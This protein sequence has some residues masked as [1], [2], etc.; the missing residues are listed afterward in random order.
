MKITEEQKDHITKSI[1]LIKEIKK[2]FNS[3]QNEL[4]E[5][6][7]GE[8]IYENQPFNQLDNITNNL[9]RIYGEYCF[10]DNFDILKHRA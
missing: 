4:N 1:L 5:T 8:H 2:L 9:F 3:L 10:N 7:I 6:Q